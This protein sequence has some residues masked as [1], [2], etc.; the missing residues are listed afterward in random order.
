VKEALEFFRGWT[1]EHPVQLLINLIAIMT[2]L[3]SLL[4]NHDH[5]SEKKRK[6]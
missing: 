4:F 2:L 5:D 6:P 1:N 3:G